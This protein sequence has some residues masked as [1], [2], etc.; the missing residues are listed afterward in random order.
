MLHRL[1]SSL[2]CLL[3]ALL[4]AC[5]SYDFTVNDKVVYRPQPLFTDFEVPDPALRGCL[6]QAIV[7]GG[8]S[9]ASQLSA[10]NCS[11]AGIASL[12]GIASFPGI[13][14]L[15]LSSNDV[16]NLVEISSITTLEEL[17]LD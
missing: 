9:V 12:D 4:S 1:L 13:K 14:I 2:V 16:R 11:H 6:E 10:L 17:Y 8:I 3:L 15:R 7:D 5:E